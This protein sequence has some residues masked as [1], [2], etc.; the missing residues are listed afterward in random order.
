MKKLFQSIKHK[1]QSYRNSVREL[2]KK[3]EYRSE[4]R[5]KPVNK[6]GAK[7]N[8]HLPKRLRGIAFRQAGL[9][10]YT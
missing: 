7:N 8:R 2:Q 4:P 9:R 3:C 1:I 10:S 5:I 6:A